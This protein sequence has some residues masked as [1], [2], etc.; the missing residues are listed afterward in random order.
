ML[1]TLSQL[2]ESSGDAEAYGIHS[3]LA[4]VN[5]VSSSY[6][7]SEIPSALALRGGG[8]GGGLYHFFPKFLSLS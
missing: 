1:Q 4:S 5:G 8:G 2:Y 3:L 6:L 7:L